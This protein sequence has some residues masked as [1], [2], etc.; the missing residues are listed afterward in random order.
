MDNE[1]YD[2]FHIHPEEITEQ[3]DTQDECSHKN[4]V[5]ENNHKICL[6]CGMVIGKNLSYEKEWRYYGI[7]DTKHYTDPNRCSARKSEDRSIFRDVDKLGFSDKV[8]SQANTLY[9]QVTRSRIFRGNTRKGIIFACV[10]H[11]HKV[12]DNPQSCEHLIEIF[13]ISRKVALKGLK[14]VNLN[15]TADASFRGIQIQTDLLIREV[16]NKFNATPSQILDVLQI[17]SYVQD[18]SVLFH[19]SRP[20]SVACGIVRFYTLKKNPE[21]TMDYFRSKV[22]LSEITINKIVKEVSRILEEK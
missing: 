9:E 22:A 6:E 10:F 5:V 15:M 17:Y 3:K 14:F 7:M 21:I 13:D 11:A 8:V 19:R 1:A 20:Q 16:M 2:F 4:L 18:R 12:M